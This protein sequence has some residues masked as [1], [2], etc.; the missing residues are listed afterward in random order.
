MEKFMLPKKML[1]II[2]FCK[3]QQPEPVYVYKRHALRKKKTCSYGSELL[4]GSRKVSVHC[5]FHALESL[6][7]LM[8][9]FV[10]GMPSTFSFFL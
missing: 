4:T 6:V 9:L 8:L 2:V 3:A 10:S 1:A 7:A 5:D